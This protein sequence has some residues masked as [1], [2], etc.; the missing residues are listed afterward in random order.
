[1]RKFDERLLEILKTETSREA[2]LRHSSKEKLR[3]MEDSKR[4][5][6]NLGIKD[7]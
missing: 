2:E 6:G 3:Y 5:S 7:I 4:M 1:M